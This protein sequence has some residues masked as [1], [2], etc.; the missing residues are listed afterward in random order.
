M[1]IKDDIYPLV[2]ADSKIICKKIDLKKE[3]KNVKSC[4]AS[5]FN[6]LAP[7]FWKTWTKLE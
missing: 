6:A 4:F 1:R 7:A 5:K 2:E 3:A